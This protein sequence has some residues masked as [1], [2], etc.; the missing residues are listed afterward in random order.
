MRVLSDPVLHNTV[1]FTNASIIL[2][3]QKYAQKTNTVKKHMHDH[4]GNSRAGQELKCKTTV[5]LK[6][7]VHPKKIVFPF[8][9]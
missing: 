1:N 6:G 4:K 9:L 7:I 5:F 2:S 8:P 3:L